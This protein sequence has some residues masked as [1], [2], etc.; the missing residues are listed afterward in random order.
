MQLRTIKS[1]T[2]CHPDVF[3]CCAEIG[4]QFE[5]FFFFISKARKAQPK[6]K[7]KMVA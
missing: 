5:A 1:K 6:R 4:V 7:K 3:V 2:G